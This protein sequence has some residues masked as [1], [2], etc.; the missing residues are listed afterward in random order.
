M[1]RAG[2]QL[3]DDVVLRLGNPAGRRILRPSFGLDL[4]GLTFTGSSVVTSHV[5]RDVVGYGNGRALGR[6]ADILE[7]RDGSI[8]VSDDRAGRIYRILLHV[9]EVVED[10]KMVAV[11]PCELAFQ[12]ELAPCHLQALHQIGGAGGPH[13]AGDAEVPHVRDRVWV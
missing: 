11:E 3:R 9:G 1:P 10:Q 5:F 13:I 7:A 2:T 6:S 4:R 8:L 12:G